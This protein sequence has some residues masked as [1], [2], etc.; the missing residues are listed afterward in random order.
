MT[1]LK[2]KFEEEQAALRQAEKDIKDAEEAIK[3]AREEERAQ[4]APSTDPAADPIILDD[5]PDPEGASP[6][7]EA[8]APPDETPGPT[9]GIPQPPHAPIVVWLPTEWAQELGDRAEK[10]KVTV[11]SFL[12]YT[13]GF[14]LQH[15]TKEENPL[16]N[17]DW[18]ETVGQKDENLAAHLGAVVYQRPEDAPIVLDDSQAASSVSQASVGDKQM[19][20]TEKIRLPGPID[21]VT[22]AEMPIEGARTEPCTCT[23]MQKWRWK[24]QDD[25]S[26]VC[27]ESQGG[28]GAMVTLPHAATSQP[29]FYATIN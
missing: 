20:T 17:L 19:P 5:L 7:P 1:R 4:H 28:C 14:K 27:D 18:E 23:P 22:G 15:R 16:K 24:L 8:A 26:R 9:E 2:E 12:R 21:D 3:A 11:Q 10:D 13:I 6:T 29:P 25:G